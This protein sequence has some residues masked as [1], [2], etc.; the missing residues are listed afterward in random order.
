MV[1]GINFENK[2]VDT[3]LNIRG[4]G[5]QSGIDLTQYHSQYDLFSFGGAGGTSN[6]NIIPF[7]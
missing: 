3:I 5:W 4:G 6:P 2:T 7:K 1:M